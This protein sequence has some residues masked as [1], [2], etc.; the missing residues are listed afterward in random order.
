[1]LNKTQILN[2][3][4]AKKSPC[5]A[6]VIQPLHRIFKSKKKNKTPFIAPDQACQHWVR[7]YVLLRLEK[8]FR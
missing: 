1:M 7:F 5:T 8:F 6:S 2:L 3:A 4:F